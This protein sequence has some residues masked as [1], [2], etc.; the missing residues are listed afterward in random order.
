LKKDREPALEGWGL[1]VQ[2]LE[3]FTVL[4]KTQKHS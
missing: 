1:L 2:G 3:T 4:T